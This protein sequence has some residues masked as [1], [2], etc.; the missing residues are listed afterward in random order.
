MCSV[1]ISRI[2]EAVEGKM[3]LAEN[4]QVSFSSISSKD[5]DLWNQKETIIIFLP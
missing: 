5:T 2:F 3:I 4:S 1:T